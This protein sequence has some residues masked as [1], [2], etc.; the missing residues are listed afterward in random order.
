VSLSQLFSPFDEVAQEHP[1]LVLHGLILVERDALQEE[2]SSLHG[3]SEP[4]NLPLQIKQRMVSNGLARLL[5]G[6]DPHAED[7]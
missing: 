2:A 5:L 3:A 6:V 4:S 7:G 1:E